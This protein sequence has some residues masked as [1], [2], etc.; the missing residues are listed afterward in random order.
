MRLRFVGDE[1]VVKGRV[2]RVLEHKSDL[3]L[4]SDQEKGAWFVV[5]KLKLRDDPSEGI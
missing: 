1:S 3:C 2:G 4:G 5:L